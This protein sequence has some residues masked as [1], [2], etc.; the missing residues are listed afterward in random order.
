MPVKQTTELLDIS[1]PTVFNWYARFREHI[2]KEKLDCL[3]SCEVAADELYTKGHCV[4]GVKEKGT[5]KI[6]LHVLNAQHAQRQHVVSFLASHV[7]AETKLCTDGS[8]LYRG[9]GNWHKLKHEY[10]IH[11]KFEFAK[12]AEI[13]GVW[14]VFRTFIRRMYHHVT[15][16]KLEDLANEFVL[17]FRKDE[18]FESPLTY[19]KICLI[20]EPFA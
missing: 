10:E 5:R 15:E 12:T 6:A 8:A 17:R 7:Q 2:P 3:L 13:E 19:W 14:G 18:I 16:Y 20:P 4:L 1:Y 11:K 9:I